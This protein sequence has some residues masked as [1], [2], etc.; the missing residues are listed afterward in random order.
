MDDRVVKVYQNHGNQS[1]GHYKSFRIGQKDTFGN[2][3]K[4]A[5]DKN[6]IN[7]SEA[8]FFSII[9]KFQNNQAT[10]RYRN[11]LRPTDNELVNDVLNREELYHDGELLLILSDRRH[12][13]A[14]ITGN[15]ERVSSQVSMDSAATFHYDLCTEFIVTPHSRLGLDANATIPNKIISELESITLREGKLQIFQR[16]KDMWRCVRCLHIFLYIFSHIFLNAGT[17]QFF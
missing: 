13:L 14:P 2:L 8:P 5:M 17:L 9:V 12:E 6:G 15:R 7:R 1:G 3:K 10:S 4:R 11:S 16:V